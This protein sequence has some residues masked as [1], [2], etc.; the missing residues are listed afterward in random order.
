MYSSSVESRSGL[1]LGH[2]NT[3]ICLV[4]NLFTVDLAL[5]LG[6]LLSYN[7]PA[8]VSIHFPINCYYVSCPW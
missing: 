7:C 6:L 3:W 1:R 8:F 5:S 4:L 2:S